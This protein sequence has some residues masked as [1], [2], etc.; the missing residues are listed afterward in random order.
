[1]LL[2]P[3]H[4]RKYKRVL[5]VSFPFHSRQL[6]LIFSGSVQDFWNTFRD[7]F[8]INTQWSMYKLVSLINFCWLSKNTSYH[9]PW[10]FRE[11]FVVSGIFLVW[12][13]FIKSELVSWWAGGL[14]LLVPRF[15]LLFWPSDSRASVLSGADL[16]PSSAELKT[17]TE[18]TKAL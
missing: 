17:K 6:V 11:T 5:F 10:V 8:E 3:G 2:L 14:G 1:M 12:F 18:K 9:F 15:G 13:H 4:H 7:H 16:F